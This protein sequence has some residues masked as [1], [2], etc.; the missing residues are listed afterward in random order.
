MISAIP[1]VS[2][3][4]MALPLLFVLIWSS[5]F[6]AAKYSAPHASP[7]ALLSLR[8]LIAGAIMAGI[9]LLAGARW[10]AAPSSRA[11]VLA[12]ILL[13]GT[14]LGPVFWV[15][16]H[17]MPAGVVALI[18]GLQP[19]ITALLAVP[20]LGEK[21]KAR[22][23]AG[24]MLGIFGVALV[25][26][27]KL[28]SGFTGV[29]FFN[30]VLMLGAVVSIAF[31]TVWQKAHGGVVDLRAGA[32]LQYAGAAAVSLIGMAAF[33]SPHLDLA[34]PALW[35][36]LGWLVFGLSIGAISLLMLLLRRGSAG[37]V[38]SLIY[39]VPGT[40]AL[41]AY[42]AFGETLVLMQMLG[43]IVCAAGVVLISRG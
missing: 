3:R 23:V 5:G 19:F 37:G 11:Q 28:T 29:S 1:T 33:E 14:Y 27:P 13:H 43:M 21:L 9:A 8:F 20:M 24:L 6:I 2:V 4:R 41:M 35:L 18:T 42:L 22:H 32:V 25:V 12:G 36:S 31:G 10:P 26:A 34:S 7:L 17:G 15:I 38:A 16:T 39:L 40:T 30:V